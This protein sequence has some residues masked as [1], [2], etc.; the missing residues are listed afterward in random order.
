MQ[1]TILTIIPQTG[2]KGKVFVQNKDI[3]FVKTGQ[4]ARVRVDAFPFTQYGELDGNVDQI[5]TDTLPPDG[6][7]FYCCSKLNLNKPYLENRSKG[8]SQGCGNYSKSKT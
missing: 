5:K 6:V 3:G 2:L 1:D 7:N 4:K 8:P